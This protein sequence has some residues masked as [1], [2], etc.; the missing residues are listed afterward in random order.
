MEK[1]MF[2]I[3]ENQYKEMT[4]EKLIENIKQ[5]DNM[6][7]NC[8]LERYNDVVNMKA[9]KFFMVGAERED[10]VQEGMIGL[11]K[12]VKSFD[13]E[14][15]NSF[16]TFA[17]MCIERQLITVV[18][19]SNRQKHIPLN[20]SISLNSAAYEDNDDMDKLEIVDLKAEDDP[21]DII[22][23]QEYSKTIE[24][25]IKENLSEY[26]LSVLYEYEKGHSYADIAEKLKTKVK[27]VDTAIQRIKKKA[28]KI[29]ESIDS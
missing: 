12:A 29:K 9:N 25:K 7:L 21:S 6:A 11:Y 24:R 4:D 19:N 18:K 16:K 17:N 20:S 3:N 8:L 28:N 23:N 2:S 13:T 5:D 10:M 27:S 26:E 15:Q 22:A 14:K 1:N